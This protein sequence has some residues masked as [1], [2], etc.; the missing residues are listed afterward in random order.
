MNPPVRHGHPRGRESRSLSPESVASE[1]H[2]TV[3]SA[4]PAA[5]ATSTTETQAAALHIPTVTVTVP[6]PL[7]S[8]Q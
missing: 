8:P 6:T 1:E 2:V 7:T 5:E 4:A 3:L